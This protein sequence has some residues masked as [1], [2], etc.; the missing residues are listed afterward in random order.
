MRI[1]S[2]WV[3]GLIVVL[4][5]PRICRAEEES[6]PGK[7]HLY[8]T[9]DVFVPSNSGDGL[10]SDIQSGMRQLSGSGYSSVGS[11]QSNAAVGGRLGIMME[12][13]EAFDLGLSGGFIAGP[14]SD[15]SILAAGGGKS[16][17]LSDKRDISYF[18]FLVEPTLNVKMSDVSSFHLGAGLGVASGR[19]EEAISCSGSAC[20]VNGAVA[21]NTSTWSGF[22]WEVSPYFSYKSV[23]FG[24]RYAGFPKFNG[25]SNNSKI[26][27]TSAGVFSGFRF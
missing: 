13:A 23:L 1:K 20:V 8:G 2:S 3:V 18:R 24:G 22:T 16:A 12:L 27:W 21:T 7:L 15:S 26:E 5:I 4:I 19:V 6:K 11:I 17:T 9:L 25:N 14:H 10:W